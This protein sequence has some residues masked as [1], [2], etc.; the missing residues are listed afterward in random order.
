[1]GTKHSHADLKRSPLDLKPTSEFKRYENR[2]HRFQILVKCHVGYKHSPQETGT[3][4]M[5]H[6]V[7]K[8]KEKQNSFFYIFLF[9]GLHQLYRDRKFKLANRCLIIGS[10]TT[11]LILFY[12]QNYPS[13]SQNSIRLDTTI[14]S[15][16]KST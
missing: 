13:G 1:M 15:T 4:T 6:D 16:P 5:E 2:F 12:R 11:K 3:T 7:S 14:P 10:S 8:K 9:Q